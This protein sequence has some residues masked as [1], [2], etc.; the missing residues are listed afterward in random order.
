M[1]KKIIRKKKKSNLFSSYIELFIRRI[2]PIFDLFTITQKVTDQRY[3]VIEKSRKEFIKKRSI[4]SGGKVAK[5]QFKHP[6]EY[7]ALISSGK[8]IDIIELYSKLNKYF[9]NKFTPEFKELRK[10]EQMKSCLRISLK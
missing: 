8:E 10:G 6:H 1:S 2:E 5:L 4:T 7:S 3:T 9:N